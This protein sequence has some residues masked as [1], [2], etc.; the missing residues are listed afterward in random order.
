MQPILTLIPK[1]V[2]LV[3]K[4]LEDKSLLF[5]ED[6]ENKKSWECK[7][8][9]AYTWYLI[10]SSNE[11]LWVIVHHIGN[12]FLESCI[13]LQTCLGCHTAQNYLGIW[14]NQNGFW[15]QILRL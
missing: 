4:L 6:I 8:S 2:H 12:W 10:Q 3:Y 7:E 14:A 5:K 11:I 15:N 1:C 13:N 9:H